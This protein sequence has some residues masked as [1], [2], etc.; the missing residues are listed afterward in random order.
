MIPKYFRCGDPSQRCPLSVKKDI[1]KKR[2]EWTCPCDNPNCSDFEVPVPLVTGIT[3]GKP[4]IVYV[5]IG[6]LGLLVLLIAV[7]GGSDPS[8]KQLGELKARLAPLES[9][10]AELECAATIKT[11]P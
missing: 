8:A 3:D 10:V 2:P 7:L 11:T 4:W 5:G 9:K 6:V 1:V